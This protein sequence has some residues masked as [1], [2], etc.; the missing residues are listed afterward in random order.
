MK[1][2]KILRSIAIAGFVYLVITAFAS[3][4]VLAY[5]D[6]PCDYYTDYCF[7]YGSPADVNIED[8]QIESDLTTTSVG[9]SGGGCDST[10]SITNILVIQPF[11][12]TLERVGDELLV[13]GSL[14]EVGGEFHKI[15]YFGLNPWSETYIE[16]HNLGMYECSLSNINP[17]VIEGST[18]SRISLVKALILFVIVVVLFTWSHERLRILKSSQS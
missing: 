14:L 10:Y 13:N 12:I 15:G 8:I 6:F 18:G 17:L 16:F 3:F 2:F 5:A 1:V 7:E 4:G 9:I 11:S